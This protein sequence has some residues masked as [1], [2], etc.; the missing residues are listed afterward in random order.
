METINSFILKLQGKA[1]LPK[2]IE[3]GHNYEVKLQGSVNKVE[4]H[5]NEDGTWDKV[6]TF[7]PVIVELVNGKGESLKLKD[8]RKNSQKMRNY[9]FKL[10]HE[11]GYIEDFDRVY[12]MFT[13]EVMGMTPSLLRSAIKRI[14][15]N[16]K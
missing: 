9:L 11:E 6:F 12:D 14:Q 16:E 3:T 2:E 7:K 1:E 13:Y 5:D 15:N 10:Y 8:S 4:L